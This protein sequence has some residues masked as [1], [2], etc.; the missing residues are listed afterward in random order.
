MAIPINIS[1][2]VTDAPYRKVSGL[3]PGPF[4]QK[5][6]MPF[7]VKYKGK[8]RRLYCDFYKG[9]PLY[10]LNVNREKVVIQFIKYNY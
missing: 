5:V 1:N 3:L 8:F 6:K 9:I 4:S 10:Y 2:V 7:K